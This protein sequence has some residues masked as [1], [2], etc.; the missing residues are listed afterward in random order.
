M[1]QLNMFGAAEAK[2]SSKPAEVLPMLEEFPNAELL[3]FEKELLGFYITNHPLTE[4]EAALANYATA[5]TREV[6]TMPEGAEVTLG[7]MINRIKR[8]VTKTG[9]SA[10]QPMCIVTLEDLEGQIEATIFSETLAQITE[11]YPK[12]IEAEQIV[13]LRGKVDKRRE[14]P[15][16]IVNDLFPIADA[17]PRLTRWVRVQID[18][19]KGAAALLNELKPILTKHKGNCQTSLTVP[20]AGSKRA[21]ID[22]DPA[23]SVRATPAIKE[24]LEYALNGHGRVEFEGAGTLRARRTSQPPLFEGAENP[25]QPTGEEEDPVLLEEV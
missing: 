1:G 11:K 2:S 25:V 10:G 20:A 3:K 18:Q 12:A 9:R 13:F 19:I 8:T 4:H 17:M 23:W 22:L 14:T 5:T 21:R 24:E 16:V 6:K 15:G 7:G